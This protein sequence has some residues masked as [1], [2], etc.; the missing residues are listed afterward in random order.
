MKLFP[1]AIALSAFGTAFGA[2]IN[3]STGSALWQVDDPNLGYVPATVLTAGEPNP[4]W[5]TAPAGSS[6]V[7]FGAV[8]GVS[9]VVGQTPGNGCSSI[10]MNPN[11]DL[12]VYS[13]TIPAASLNSSIGVLNF[14][15]GGDNRVNVFVGN[16]SEIE[17][18]NTGSETNGIAYEQLA[19]SGLPPT[20]AG[21][22]QASYNNCTGTVPFGAS[23][24]NGDGSLSIYAYAYND[25]IPGCPICGNPSGF[26]L[27]GTLTTL[28]S[29]GNSPVPEPASFGLVSLAGLVGLAFR[30]K[31]RC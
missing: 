19:C 14:I 25:P 6:W 30:M 29:N 7:S 15:F 4:A 16:N 3:I 1:L 12:W 24:L 27:E 11:G 18:W 21:N 22:T 17:T 26:L 20:N 2:T 23:N 9:C 13:L 8:Q 5:A 31:R 10:I 28:G